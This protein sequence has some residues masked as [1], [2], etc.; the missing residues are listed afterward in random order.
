MAKHLFFPRIFN[1][2]STE[3]QPESLT[4]EII[5]GITLHVIQDLLNNF[6]ITTD[7][8]L[9]NFDFDNED[10]QEILIRIEIKLER[11]STDVSL[12]PE[13]CIPQM[14]ISI[15]TIAQNIMKVIEEIK[16]DILITKAS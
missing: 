16:P 14:N 7:T 13:I 2:D 8:N 11:L 10:I 12:E 6:T 9:D 3:N 15:E 1:P 4:L 5:T